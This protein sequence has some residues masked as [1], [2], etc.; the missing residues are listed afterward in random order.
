MHLE[1]YGYVL[2][3]GYFQSVFFNIIFYLHRN[4]NLVNSRRSHFIESRAYRESFERLGYVIK[5]HWLWRKFYMVIK[6]YFEK[7]EFCWKSHFIIIMRYFCIK[8]PA[9]KWDFF[10]SFKN[11]KYYLLRSIRMFAVSTQYI[12]IYEISSPWLVGSRLMG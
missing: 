4:T 3:M 5:C 1:I 9:S 12:S 7:F 8:R 10:S 6:L 2:L 11:L